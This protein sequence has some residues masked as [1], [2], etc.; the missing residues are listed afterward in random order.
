[1][2][3]NRILLVTAILSLIMFYIVKVI[4]VDDSQ[5]I[6]KA[7]RSIQLS[8]ASIVHIEYL[9]DRMAI[10][11]YESSFA[12][13][14]YF[15]SAIFKENIFTGWRLLSSGG[16]QLLPDHKLDWG[17]S[18]MSGYS[19]V[20]TDLINGKVLDPHINKVKVITET[21]NEYEAK[22]VDYH[23]G[24]KLWFLLSKG[25]D[26]VGSTIIGLNDEGE[27]IEEFVQ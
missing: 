26:L 12:E 15:G 25:E 19:S 5:A 11:F 3:R 6:H 7:F 9:E 18:N 1:M 2:T 4:A 21:G 14:Q 10:A 17:F 23:T 22:V 24:A 8:N 20:Y 27:T 13:Q 16:G